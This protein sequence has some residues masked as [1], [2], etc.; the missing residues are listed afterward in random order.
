[1][2]AE[3]VQEPHDDLNVVNGEHAAPARV[4]DEVLEDL[5]GAQLLELLVGA[6][7][8]ELGQELG[9]VCD[10]VGD[11]GLDLRGDEVRHLLLLGSLHGVPE[12]V[13]VP[14]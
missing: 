7:L 2:F 14:V 13:A 1:M 11:E 10:E 5:G 3:H 12:A 4:L 6:D 9:A 8:D